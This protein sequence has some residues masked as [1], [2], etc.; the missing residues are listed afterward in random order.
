MILSP[1]V[2][3]AAKLFFFFCREN[4]KHFPTERC[5]FPTEEFPFRQHN[6]LSSNFEWHIAGKCRKVLE[7]FRAQE[8]RALAYFTRQLHSSQKL[9]HVLNSCYWSYRSIQND[10]RLTFFRR[11]TN[12]NS[13]YRIVLP[14]ELIY[15]TE[16]DLW[17]FQQKSLIADTDSA[18]NSN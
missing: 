14:K 15:I 10:Y 6:A 18:L 2:Q 11:T 12:S 16:T 9:L 17:K 8:A 3:S 4:K 13:R 7:A 5:A 1:P